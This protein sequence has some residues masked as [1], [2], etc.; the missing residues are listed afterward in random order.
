MNRS[1]VIKRLGYDALRRL[2]N[3][4]YRAR[5]LSLSQSV[6][7]CDL[8]DSS[9]KGLVRSFCVRRRTTVRV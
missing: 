5:R 9:E 4:R 1:S 3:L 8:N 2:D 6:A 7:H